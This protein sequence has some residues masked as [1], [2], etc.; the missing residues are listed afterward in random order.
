MGDFYPPRIE[1]IKSRNVRHVSGRRRGVGGLMDQY[2]ILDRRAQ[3]QDYL[4]HMARQQPGH[5]SEEALRKQ[6]I[7]IFGE[8]A[9]LSGPWADYLAELEKADGEK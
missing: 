9:K 3:L 5:R 7:E 2:F 8:P 1:F 4:T 6:F